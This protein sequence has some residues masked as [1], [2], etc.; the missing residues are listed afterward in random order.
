MEK[1]YT[2]RFFDHLELT[3]DTRLYVRLEES[4]SGSLIVNIKEGAGSVEVVLDA[5]TYSYGKIML[6]NT[7]SQDLDIKVN[8]TLYK[9]ATVRMGFMDLEKTKATGRLECHLVQEGA[10][11]EIYTGQL[12]QEHTSKINAME[13]VHE[14]PHTY[15]NMHNFAVQFDDSYYEMI[16]NGNI[17]DKCPQSQSHQ[18]TRVLTLGRGHKNKVIPLLLIDENDVKASHALT[19]GQPDASQMYYLQSRGLSRAMAMGLLSIG[20]FMPVIDLIDDEEEKKRL[21]EE[22]ESKV[23]LYGHR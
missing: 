11:F 21:R 5:A 4:A 15:G 19:I 14:A 6:H 20:Y 16:A 10:D 18:E 17:H 1:I 23:G 2:G 9:D 3:E 8:C 7:S 12:V 13:I 22:M